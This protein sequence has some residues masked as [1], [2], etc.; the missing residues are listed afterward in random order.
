MRKNFFYTLFVVLPIIGIITIVGCTKEGDDGAPGADGTAVCGTCHDVSSDIVAKQTQF[1]SSVHATGSTFERNSTDCAVCHTSQGFIERIAS[2][3][4]TTAATI[5]NPAPV[6]CRTCH[7]IHTNYNTN[8]Y[9]L[10]SS[11]PVTLWI[12]NTVLDMGNANLCIN[13]HQPRIPNPLPTVGGAD[14]AITSAYWGLHHGPQ[15]TMLGGTGGFEI[16]GSVSYANSM[17]TSL[18]T[19]GCIKCHMP[20]AYGSQAGGHTFSMTYAYHGHDAVYQEGCSDC[21]ADAT[22]LTTKI[23]DTA[24]D[25]DALLASLRS[26]LLTEGVID[27]TD[28]AIPG[29]FTATEAGCA[30]NYLFVLEDRSKGA[31]NFSYAK[32]LLTNS[33]EA[34][35]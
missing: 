28:H 25:I 32:A 29:T 30:M 27:S 13:C 7:K 4:Q 35:P 8:D 18:I 20:S 16:A 34:L 21:H 19:D 15:G 17:H 1:Q 9:D 26:K 12:N 6:N 31:H 22:A 24:D 11:S 2:G 10:T 14:V 33:I 5:S 23:D 3:A